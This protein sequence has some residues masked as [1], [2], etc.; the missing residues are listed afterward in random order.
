MPDP[1]HR[2]LRLLAAHRI[3]GR[4]GGCQFVRRREDCER[5]P[6]LVAPGVVV[7]GPT[8]PQPAVEGADEPAEGIADDEQVA[9][10]DG[11]VRERG[12]M[13]AKY[14]PIP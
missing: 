7:A 3:A 1:F 8:L 13:S 14:G 9:L 2:L 11:D 5:D 10:P 6:L 12:F 4:E